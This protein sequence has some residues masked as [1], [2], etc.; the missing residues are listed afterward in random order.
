MIYTLEKA[1]LISKQL[2]KITTGYS[3]YVVG[4]FANVDFWI[5]EVVESL[6]IIDEHRNRFDNMLNAQK[7]WIE[8]HGTVI[9]QHCAICGGICEFSN[10][11]P[12][13]PKLKYKSEKNE[14]RKH[15]VDSAYYFLIRCYKIGLLTNEELKHK[16]DLIGTSIDTYD[17]E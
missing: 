2:K 6:R 1:N 12:P 7:I 9:H 15:L 14:T 4:Q 13:L 5:E 16:C 8:E 11:K 3:H 10:G 17:L